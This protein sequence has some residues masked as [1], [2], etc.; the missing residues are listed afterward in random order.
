MVDSKM[1]NTTQIYVIANVARQVKQSLPSKAG[2][3]FAPQT[4]LA[5]TGFRVV[6][7][8]SK[9]FRK[10]TKTPLKKLPDESFLQ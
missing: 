7:Y 9:K 8:Q 3:C 4:T 6:P 10:D 2:D 1:L 5:M